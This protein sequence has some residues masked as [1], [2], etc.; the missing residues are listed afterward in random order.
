MITNPKAMLLLAAAAVSAAAQTTAWDLVQPD[1]K[2]LMGVDLKSLRESAVG[3]AIR[4]QMKTQ[5]A[6]GGMR[7][8]GQT[9][10]QAS[11]RQTPGQAKS[12]IQSPGQFQTQL[13]AMA[14]GLLDQ[15]DQ[16]YLSSPANPSAIPAAG[17]KTNPPFLVV[18][19]GHIP[20]AQIK[21]FLNGASRPY[22]GVDVYRT[23]QPSATG[24]T[25]PSTQINPTSVA[26]LQRGTDG[27]TL[28][29]GDEKSVLAAIA[30]REGTLPP[31][32]G[33]IKRAQAL[34]STH[35]FWIIADGPLP[36]FGPANAP[37]AD[38][39]TSAIAQIKG[40]DMGISLR[41]GLQF[42]LILATASDAAA[43]QIT[44]LFSAQIQMAMLAQPNRPE[45]AEIM[46]K[47]HIA[48][49]GNRMRV[50]MALTKDEFEQQLRS[51]QAARAAAATPSPQAPAQ[52]A[53]RS[54][55]PPTP[56]K[57]IIYGLEGGPRE[58]QTTH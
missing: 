39:L 4:E 33:I 6:P 1:A 2:M 20:I 51:A 14:E 31:A 16:V 11:P 5:T 26:L 21:P 47:V 57:I 19:E 44:Q 49:D 55:K 17:A 10:L 45:T 9:P 46:R 18:V 32:S 7:A 15:I 28:L 38:P 48:A 35:A 34:A 30:R 25:N 29:L 56:G 12:Q 23:S 27:E 22:R 58:I 54:A 53:A 36:Q 43:A 37:A 50:D 42:E 24:Q 13:L 8:P 52:P 41:D 3:Q 40:M